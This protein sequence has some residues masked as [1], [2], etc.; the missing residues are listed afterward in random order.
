MIHLQQTILPEMLDVI[1]CCVNKS[2]K[3]YRAYVF[4][5][6]DDSQED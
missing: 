6:N 5:K 3:D 1:V 4:N 2:G